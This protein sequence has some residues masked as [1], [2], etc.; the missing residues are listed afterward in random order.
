MMLHTKCQGSGPCGFR[1]DVFHV[2]RVQAKFKSLTLGQA[3][4]GPRD[5]T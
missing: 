3:F 1:Q 4:L 2:F 5:I